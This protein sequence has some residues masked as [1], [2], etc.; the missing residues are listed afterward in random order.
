MSGHLSLA[1]RAGT[2]SASSVPF[3]QRKCNLDLRL[4]LSQQLSDYRLWGTI[5]PYHVKQN[6]ARKN[7]KIKCIYL[8]EQLEYQ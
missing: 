7:I 8:V 6:V 5:N 1:W 4:V 2:R 3:L